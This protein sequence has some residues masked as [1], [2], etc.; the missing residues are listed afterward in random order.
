[1][2]SQCRSS[3]FRAILFLLISSVWGSPPPLPQLHHNQNWALNAFVEHVGHNQ[4][5]FNLNIEVVVEGDEAKLN[6]FF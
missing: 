2:K 3:K 4:M 6:V 5:D 1:M